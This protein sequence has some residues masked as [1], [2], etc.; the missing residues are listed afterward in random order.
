MSGESFPFDEK[1][2]RIVIE[3]LI[4][5]SSTD[6][7]CLDIGCGVGY[8]CSLMAEKGC[9]VFGIDISEAAVAEARKRIPDGSFSLAKSSGVLSY[10]RCFFDSLICLGVLEH[11]IDPENVLKES[12]RVLKNGGRSIFLVP[13]AYSPYFLFSKGTGQILEVPRKKREWIRMFNAAGFTIV[14][15]GKDPGPT[16]VPWS[17][18]VKRTKL[19]LNRG[20]NL[21]P[22]D[23]TYQFIFLLEKR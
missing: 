16:P 5:S 7:R 3:P 4:R 13:N 11:M 15:I 20:L 8:A 9:Q 12:Y 18:A 17:S 10:S 6:Q 21:L 1:R 23:L 2:T 14:K 19:L 22:V